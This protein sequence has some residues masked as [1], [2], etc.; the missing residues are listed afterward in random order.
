[1]EYKRLKTRSLTA[2]LYKAGNNIGAKE[3]K[4]ELMWCHENLAFSTYSYCRK[5]NKKKMS[6]KQIIN[7]TNTG[8]C[9][10]LSY[11]LKNRLKKKYGANSYLVPAT[12]PDSFKKP[13]YLELSHVALL[14]PGSKP[15]IFYIADPAFYFIKPIK[16]NLRK[17]SVP[18]TCKMSNIYSSNM[19]NNIEH[20]YTRLNV[21]EEDLDLNKYQKIKKN[22]V[23]VNCSS[24]VGWE[25]ITNSK[26]N[27]RGTDPN[28]SWEYMVTE[29]LN[30]D[31]AI[32]SFFM[33]YWKKRPFITRTEVKYGKVYCRASIHCRENNNITI[34]AYNI[35]FYDGLERDLT[36]EEIKKWV[37]I[38]DMKFFTEKSWRDYLLRNGRCIY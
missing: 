16:V 36:K 22:T 12:V 8:N 21:L 33:N 2:K 34:K 37:K 10:G 25:L 31:E 14:I 1:M 9:I 15:W 7:K 5:A 32:T 18:G 4:K 35:P 28:L 3:I 20:F 17:W 27:Y 6:S 23:V 29:I 38:F 26:S 24:Y 19:E 13:G 11:G 30:P